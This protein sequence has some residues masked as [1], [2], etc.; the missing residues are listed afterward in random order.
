[1]RHVSEELADIFSHFFDLMLVPDM[2]SVLQEYQLDDL[3]GCT[4]LSDFNQWFHTWSNL[5][6]DLV[7]FLV[8]EDIHL[9]RNALN[10]FLKSLRY[11]T[12]SIMTENAINFSN[13]V[14]VSVYYLIYI[15]PI[16]TPANIPAPLLRN[17][18]RFLNQARDI[19]KSENRGH[20]IKNIPF[21]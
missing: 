12:K 19:N 21:F 15:S 5:M 9:V 13:I 4:S 8:A 11:T 2:S 17:A 10:N 3:D 14:R 20:I 16:H 7:L 18:L 6:G 1:M